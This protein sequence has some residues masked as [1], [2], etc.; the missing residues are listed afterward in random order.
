MEDIEC[1]LWFVALWQSAVCHTWLSVVTQRYCMRNV[2]YCARGNLAD[3][4]YPLTARKLKV[5]VANR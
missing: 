4:H 3:D 5:C 1:P 2:Y